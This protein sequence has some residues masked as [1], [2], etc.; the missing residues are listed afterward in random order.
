MRK[1]LELTKRSKSLFSVIAMVLCLSVF[2]STFG[3]LSIMA[4]DG[5][6]WDGT[7]ATGFASGT[8][9]DTDPYIIND[10]AQLRYLITLGADATVGKHYKL[11][12]DI[13]LND[14]SVDGWYTQSGLNVWESLKMADADAA[15]FRGTFD[16]AGHVVY[17]LYLNEILATTSGSMDLSVAAGLF[18]IIGGSAVIKNVGVDKAYISVN[19]S[20]T[21]EIA[22]PAGYVGAIGGAVEGTGAGTLN[23]N[24]SECYAGADVQLVGGFIG[25]FGGST[26]TGEGVFL[27]NC[28]MLLTGTANTYSDEGN[29]PGIFASSKVK[30]V[31]FSG[32]YAAKGTS[33]LAG[34][35]VSALEGAAKNYVT[36]WGSGIA[37]KI[38]DAAI[39]G[40]AAKTAMPEL[41]F[42]NV[43]MTTS[44]YPVLR[45]FIEGARDDSNVWKGTTSKPTKG[46]GTSATD[47]ILIETPEE[48]A[49]IVK[50]GMPAGTFYRLENDIYLNDISKMDWATGEP[51]NG[52]IPV[53]WYEAAQ[54]GDHAGIF[55]GNGHMVYGLYYKDSTTPVWDWNGTGLFPAP[56][57][58]LRVSKLGI[59]KCYLEHPNAVGA[60]SGAKD[61]TKISGCSISFDQCFV[62][63]ATTLI[64]DNV[65]A[66]VGIASYAVNISNSY[67][68]GTMDYSTNGGGF[69][70]NWWGHNSST[71][72]NVYN[73]KG[74]MG[75]NPPKTH[76]NVYVTETQGTA[77]LLTSS[78]MKGLDVLT[79]GAMSGLGNYFKATETY[80]ILSVFAP[81]GSVPVGTEPWNG[82]ETQP[83][84]G[85]GASATDPILIET[86]EELA[87]IV[88]NG[89]PTGT[90]YRLE[91][92][93]YLND[94]SKM[95]WATGEPK[96]GYTPKSWFEKTEFG[97]DVVHA[98]NFD[99]NGHMV[100]GLYY[101]TSTSTTYWNGTGL[102]PAPS[103][104]LSVSKLGIDKCYLEHPDAVGAFAGARNSSGSIS[105]D[106]CF[107][108]GNT[109][110]VSKNAG[111]FVGIAGYA[112][113]IS[114]SYNLGT[115]VYTT[116][117]GGF[118]ADWWGH[119]NSTF[120]NV[121]NAKGK[122]GGNNP[123]NLTN[124]YVIE[125]QGTAILLT[126][127]QM[128]G[129]DVLTTGA[130]SGLGICFVATD[131][132][133]VL[134]VFNSTPD[135]ETDY[136]NG[137]IV[138]PSEGKGTENDPIIIKNAAEL[139]FVVASFGE[140]K[141]YKLAN[142]IYIND[143]TKINWEDGTLL[144]GSYV[145][146]QWFYGTASGS[147]YYK[148]F[149]TAENKWK[150]TLDG[151]GFTVYGLYYPNDF[152]Y[153]TAGLIPGMTAA[154]V[155]NLHLSKSYVV[156]GQYVGAI[157]STFTGTMEGVVVDDTVTVVYKKN[158]ESDSNAC[159]GLIGYGLT[160]VT[161]KNC[162]FYG[163]LVLRQS[164][165]H[166]YGL[167]GTSWDTKIH[168][169]SCF[170]MG[171][172]PFT[173]ATGT[174]SYSS[175]AEYEAGIEALKA[176][177][178]DMYQVTNVY[179]DT[180]TKDNNISWK[181][182]DGE[183]SVSGTY[184]VFTFEELV[185]GKMNGENALD[186]M[187]GLS[188][189]IW[190]ATHRAPKTKLWAITNG[191]ADLDGIQALIGDYTA[192]RK[193][194]IGTGSTS[195]TDS[196]RNG[197][198]D[199]ADLVKVYNIVPTVT[200]GEFTYTLRR[201]GDIKDYTIIYS[202]NDEQAKIAAE[203]LQE[204]YADK[205][206]TL[207]V[208]SDDTGITYEKEILIGN[209]SRGLHENGLPE[210]KYTIKV[211]GNFVQL[212][213]GAN[214]TDA[215]KTAAN[216][217]MKLYYPYFAAETEGWYE[218]GLYENGGTV[219]LKT[220]TSYN[221]S[222]KTYSYVWGD[223]FYG[224]TLNKN[225]WICDV[226]KTKM[227]GYSDLKLYD[228]EEA[229]KV[230]GG[231]L[232]LTSGRLEDGTYT[233][234]ASVHTQG[235]MEYRYGYIEIGATIPFKKGV[236]PSF[237]TQSQSVLGGRQNFNYFT[238]IDIF[239][240]FGSEVVLYSN[241]HKW[242][243]KGHEITNSSG[244]TVSHISVDT[245]SSYIQGDVLKKFWSEQG[246][247]VYRTYGFGWDSHYL[248]MYING[249]LYGR[250]DI[251][252]AAIFGSDYAAKD[253]DMTGFNDPIFI[254]FNNHLFTPKAMN[255]L[256]SWGQTAI[257]DNL[258]SLPAS[259]TI[260][261]VRLYQATDANTQLWTKP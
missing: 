7:V 8:G 221:S 23:T 229:V 256:G 197:I 124:V 54:C 147:A 100:Y 26:G 176:K 64:S 247:Y 122:M 25:M 168:A 112:V 45:V 34:T 186:N 6:N 218:A 145:P 241:V 92:D 132:Y 161:L 69:I 12:K 156:G 127:S 83:S 29:R 237:W 9:S 30:N 166:I 126:P 160:E 185:T 223:D 101:N 188:S 151:N 206:I 24:I 128:R 80:P 205:G 235:M 136:W 86:P 228:T 257:A 14:V 36:S 32:C 68:L 165:A 76:T 52:Y 81:T 111:A 240:V 38:T 33:N 117:G 49:Y 47:P 116:K 16:G 139:A 217:F 119:N 109:T 143:I 72:V 11:A 104:G 179:T 233:A 191:D 142:D 94:I 60:F 114:N 227:N 187:P 149:Y 177:Y 183:S 219:T 134:A 184:Q 180:H 20:T 21:V 95:D 243:E 44:T 138:K 196:D 141:Y 97:D 215:L 98:G 118:I 174:K 157:T 253:S 87:Y 171:Y 62:G 1:F 225:K 70:G 42:E 199:I 193:A 91:N 245:D 226:N 89:M 175:K 46:T 37:G 261:Y 3:G 232:V 120:V 173:T 18:P 258:T 172:Q 108:G 10:G 40:R 248:Y 113:N 163:K 148:G 41:D 198:T 255:E 211:V 250:Y 181:Y 48:L 17:G 102:F 210:G 84:K 236:W 133:P 201:I 150:G 73:A 2:L 189:D 85:T 146:N 78:Q 99:G 153:T 82:R 96:D 200:K 246:Q 22:K 169:S 220:S 90:F 140:G 121:Y 55:D 209:T 57:N 77:I 27:T 71:F 15:Q 162:A 135:S 43:Y 67:N 129:P 239:E 93:I 50:N 260:D 137:S 59:D 5:K 28:Y 190:Y 131:T 222:T 110:L 159:A 213:A 167:V 125:E 254:I 158:T 103:N 242:Y 231:N 105:F 152:S 230:T 130:M 155:K 251:T 4:G 107:V 164:G 19:T 249:S 65:G 106:Q 53:E 58:G 170:S 194:I 203:S 63:E 192:I 75:G 195:Y 259:Y 234:P 252:Q 66:F 61:N 123:K 224:D 115:M 144:D 51:M 88:K 216:T 204:M 214:L 39:L 35:T 208:S 238:E 207:S 178:A 13:Y 212:S 74:K 56:A 154:T 244:N 182:T 79:T 31:K 202:A